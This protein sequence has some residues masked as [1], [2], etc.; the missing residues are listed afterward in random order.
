MQSLGYYAVPDSFILFLE[1]QV[2]AEPVGSQG[3]AV[4]AW[5]CAQRAES[6]ICAFQ[7]FLSEM[8]VVSNQNHW[9]MLPDVMGA[10]DQGLS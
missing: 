5:E 7:T 4:V 6:C 2:W 8:S 10:Q 1:S 9:F 3:T